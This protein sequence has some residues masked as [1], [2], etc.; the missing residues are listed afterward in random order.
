M[1]FDVG[2]L[3]HGTPPSKGRSCQDELKE[4]T[5]ATAQ[6]VKTM[7]PQLVKVANRARSD[8]NL[9]FDNLAHLIDVDL[10]RSAY[11]RLRKAAA[12]GVDHVTYDD[13]GATL[14]ENLQD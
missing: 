2:E 5:M 7:S 10:L 4:R 8:S 13:Y 6:T 3:R 11:K 9:R 12:V 1:S 14:E